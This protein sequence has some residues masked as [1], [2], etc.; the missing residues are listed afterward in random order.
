MGEIASGS[1][2]E[3]FIKY[4]YYYDGTIRRRL[5]EFGAQDFDIYKNALKRMDYRPGDI[6]IDIGA[7]MGED[8]GT[9]AWTYRPRLVFLLEPAARDSPEFDDRYLSLA[10]ELGANELSGVVLLASADLETTV[11]ELDK[12]DSKIL[13]PGKTYIQPIPSYAES[14][15][16]PDNSVTKLSMIHSIYEF[17][18]LHA[19]LS[20]A[21]R[22]MTDDALGLVITNGPNDKLR[23]KEKLKETADVLTRESGGQITY[24]SPKTVS[25]K[26]D[27]VRA[28]QAI[29][30]YFK[31]VTTVPYKDEMVINAGRAPEY[32][33]SYDSYKRR[34]DP[35]V[36]SDGR[37]TRVRQTVLIDVM[38]KEI[39]KFGGYKDT[40]DI[41]AIYF[42][43]PR[44]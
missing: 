41:A 26:V 16:L 10:A 23:F 27:Y 36:P 9:I 34:F 14:I 3:P 5:H 43:R 20:E 18:N 38:D 13:R 32:I 6:A 33:Y 31:E 39:A 29:G 15:P 7:G 19:A 1:G 44:K 21:A 12:P 11:R 30:E 37:W 42:R 35:A 24:T 40:I 22:V 28:A 25:S 17:H 2:Y 4:A 8:G